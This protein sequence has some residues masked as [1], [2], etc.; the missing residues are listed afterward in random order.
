V[1]G[2]GQ[3]LADHEAAMSDN[4]RMRASCSW[5]S[6]IID[7]SDEGGFCIRAPIVKTE[8]NIEL[9]SAC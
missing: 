1:I 4:K 9:M 3:H 6:L 5:A 8:G 2:D 7:A